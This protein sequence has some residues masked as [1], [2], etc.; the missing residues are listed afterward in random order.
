MRDR[1]IADTEAVPLWEE[2]Q[3]DEQEDGRV[4]NVA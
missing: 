1:T 2:G 4:F 3:V